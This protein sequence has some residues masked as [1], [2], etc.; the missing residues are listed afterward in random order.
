MVLFKIEHRGSKWVVTSED[1]SK[2]LG[3]H[4]NKADAEAQL[5]AVEASKARQASVHAGASVLFDV[6][7]GA[8]GKLRVGIWDRGAT[9][10][11]KV[12]DGAETEFSIDT[13][14]QFIDNWLKRG[15]LI[16]CCYNHQS[17]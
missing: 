2:V 17:A 3:S 10:G 6:A 11:H 1:G 8:D 13:F 14:G 9:F 7:R 16:A 15:E 12:K 5:R 4:D